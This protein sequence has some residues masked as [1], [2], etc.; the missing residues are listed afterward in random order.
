MR[1]LLM[2]YHHLPF[3]AKSKLDLDLVVPDFAVEMGAELAR[4]HRAGYVVLDRVRQIARLVFADGTVDIA[5]QVGDSILTDLSKRD[6]CMNAIA[7]PCNHFVALAQPLADADL[8]RLIDPYGGQ[9][10]LLAR[11][12]RMVTPENLQ[13]DPLRLLRGY[14]QAAQLGFQLEKYT[15]LTS[16]KLA[17][18]LARVAA[19]RVT[20][21][22]FY[23]LDLP[24]GTDWLIEALQDRILDAW[25]PHNLQIDRLRQIDWAIAWLQDNYPSLLGYFATDLAGDRSIAANTRF[26]ALVDSRPTRLELSKVEQKFAMTLTRSLKQLKTAL[27]TNQVL[28]QYNLFQT[29]GTSFPAVVA[30]ALAEGISSEPLSCY[31]NQ[32]LDP[33]HPIAHPITLVSGEQLKQALHLTPSPKIGELLSQ[34]RLAQIQGK[35]VNSAQ[36]I[37]YAADLLSHPKPLS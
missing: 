12:V 23:L 32:W 33:D 21:E 19:E 11:Q 3:Y 20:T 25:L 36:A 9:T 6:F 5:R 15:R 28:D 31:L 26:A 27:Q 4:K 2:A 14:R 13:S 30:I 18:S 17:Q 8:T 1:N 22:V 29:S 24:G 16:T 34:I 37:A 10:D 7:L 35:I